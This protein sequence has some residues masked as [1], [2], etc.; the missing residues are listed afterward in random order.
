MRAEM[1]L[2]VTADQEDG[3]GQRDLSVFMFAVEHDQLYFHD[4]SCK[5]AQLPLPDMSG[6][7]ESGADARITLARQGS[8]EREVSHNKFTFYWS[9]DVLDSQP[10]TRIP[11]TGVEQAPASGS[12]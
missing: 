2:A 4:V 11:E 6:Y 8:Q 7:R 12:S 3:R 9:T 10:P 5:E 1:A